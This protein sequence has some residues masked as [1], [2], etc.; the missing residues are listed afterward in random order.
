MTD[1]DLAARKKAARAAAQARRDGAAQ[2]GHPDPS[3]HL[4]AVLAA[5]AGRAVSGYAPMRAEIDPMPALAQAAATGPVGLPV[6]VARGA[7]L[8]FRAWTPGC[9]M[10]EGPFRAMV[11]AEGPEMVPEVLVVPL[12]AF[13]RG[14]GRLG[15][16]GGFYDRTLEA[17][18]ARG[19]V[20]AVGYAWAAQEDPDLPLEPTDQTLDL[21]VTERGVIDPARGRA[22]ASRAAGPPRTGRHRV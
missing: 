12:L 11:P 17:L 13:T 7:P 4:R 20:L 18:R 9:A 22:A 21:I 2:A 6:I 19:P 10:V 16:G 8:A 5:H 15:Y 3:A 1:D 14:G